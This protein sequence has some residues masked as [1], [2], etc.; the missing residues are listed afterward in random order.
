[1]YFQ[2]Y[3]TPTQHKNTS[4]AKKKYSYFDSIVY[5][6]DIYEL[7]LKLLLLNNIN[8]LILKCT[9]KLPIYNKVKYNK[10]DHCL[11]LL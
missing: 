1:M 9:R 11:I 3:I 6:R 8:I 4:R 10:T 7:S 2:S 5:F